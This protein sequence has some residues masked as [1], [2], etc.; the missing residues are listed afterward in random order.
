[1]LNCNRIEIVKTL[2]TLAI[3]LLLG[4]KIQAA[5]KPQSGIA[6]MIMKEQKAYEIYRDQDWAIAYTWGKNTD[7]IANFKMFKGIF[8]AQKRVHVLITYLGN[9]DPNGYS[10]FTGA[11]LNNLEIEDK[12]NCSVLKAI[13]LNTSQLPNSGPISIVSCKLPA[14]LS[15]GAKAAILALQQR[16]L[17]GELK[18]DKTKKNKK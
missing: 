12:E 11:M 6:V 18:Y 5:Q 1:M 3:P 8:K 7:P 10:P 2:L 15:D 13:M 14:K 17:S 16:E 9:K 4:S